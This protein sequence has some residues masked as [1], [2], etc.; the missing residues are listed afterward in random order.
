MRVRDIQHRIQYI[1]DPTPAPAERA[2]AH[3]RNV[4]QRIEFAH[5]GRRISKPAMG[6]GDPATAHMCIDQLR[7]IWMMGGAS[8]LEASEASVR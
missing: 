8:F 3:A 5:G 1:H 7:G 2:L 4:K 6:T